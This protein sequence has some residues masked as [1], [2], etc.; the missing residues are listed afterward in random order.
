[1]EDTDTIP[2]LVA[3]LRLIARALEGAHTANSARDIE[4][5]AR[6]L[7]FRA[8]PSNL[9]SA[10]NRAL[11]MHSPFRRESAFVPPPTQPP[12]PSP[13]SGHSAT[14]PPL[15]VRVSTRDEDAEDINHFLGQALIAI[16]R[17]DTRE[18]YTAVE[19]AR[20]LNYRHMR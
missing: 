14:P 1:V 6:R 18:A 13:D 9:T 4:N 8:R 2:V 7:D 15:R 10:L 12:P 5:Q 20:D 19:S 16:E 3:D 17:G 11:K